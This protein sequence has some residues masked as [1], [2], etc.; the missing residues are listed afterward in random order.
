V[1][2]SI[3]GYLRA[4][5]KA[6]EQHK[7]KFEITGDTCLVAVIPQDDLAP[8]TAIIMS[9]GGVRQTNSLEAKRPVLVRVIEVGP[10]F[11]DDEGKSVGPGVE[12]GDILL[13]GSNSVQEIS[14]YGKLQNYGRVVLGICGAGERMFSWKGEQAFND[15]FETVLSEVVN[16]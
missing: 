11:Y 3:T 1:S 12:P 10:G 15:Y 5:A 8:K 16:G 2:H 14:Q 4:L 13:V 6:R 7:E 9:S